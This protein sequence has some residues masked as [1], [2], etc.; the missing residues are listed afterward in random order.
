M[1]TRKA[2]CSLVAL[3]LLTT[4]VSTAS[5]QVTPDPARDK[6]WGGVST[7]TAVAAFGTAL[8]MPRFFYPAPEVTV[9]YKGRWH[10]SQLAPVMTLATLTLINEVAFTDT[11]KSQRP[12]CDDTNFGLTAHCQSYGGPSSHGFAA[13]SAFGMGVAV[14]LVDTMKWSDGRVSGVS[15]A[16]N[17]ALP[18]I[19]GGITIV[20]RSQGN[21]E[22]GGQ[23]LSGTL[24]GLGLGFVTGMV[25]AE[26]SRPECGYSGSLICW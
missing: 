6:T 1:T 5:A 23:I 9:G 18:L 20:G 17:I 13:G 12:G 21:Y 26:M 2:V 24:L 19:L 11:V 15:V 8:I 3:M 25:Y 4:T 16:T 7:A 14:F 22:N 10:L